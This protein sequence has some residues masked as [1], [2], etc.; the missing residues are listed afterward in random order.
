MAGELA[1]GTGL[2]CG[3]G[4]TMKKAM[5][6]AAGRGVRMRPL[7]NHQ[8]KPLL[9]LD[10]RPLLQH[11]LER[12]SRHGCRSIVINCAYLGRQIQ[13]FFGNGERF[14][15]S[16]AYSDE[17]AVPLGTV[18]GV[19]RALP[20]LGDEP[21]WLVSADIACDFP[22]LPP[23][24]PRGLAHLLLVDNPG[25]HPSGDFSFAAGRLLSHAGTRFTYSGVGIY[26]PEIFAVAREKALAELLHEAIAARCVSAQVHQGYWMDVGTP[27]RLQHARRWLG[28]GNQE[29]SGP[30]A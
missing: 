14:G 19:Q 21:F 25:H 16:I 9:Q 23:P 18:A 3:G 24:A 22:C 27:E 12:L 6:L 30:D 5:I 17:G 1:E 29:I 11:Q 10:G 20:L 26:W 8:P 2:S 4:K 7:T 28:G 15:V 13:D